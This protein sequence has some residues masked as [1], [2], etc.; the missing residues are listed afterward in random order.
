MP[1]ACANCVEAGEVDFDYPARRRDEVGAIAA[2]DPGS[3]ESGALVGGNL[4]AVSPKAAPIS[5]RPVDL[6]GG[7]QEGV[8]SVA[9]PGR[10][11]DR[12]GHPTARRKLGTATAGAMADLH[13]AFLRQSGRCKP[14]TRVEW[15]AQVS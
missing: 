12:K 7:V 8:K 6:G 11:P 14:A 9:R 13:L 5:G 3:R 15:R 10:T 2:A 4:P 1:A